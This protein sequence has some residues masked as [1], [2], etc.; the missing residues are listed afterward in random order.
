MPPTL[1]LGP[2]SPQGVDNPDPAATDGYFVGVDIGQLGLLDVLRVGTPGGTP[3]L[4]GNLQINVPATALPLNP[5]V[6]GSS[7]PLDAADDRL[8]SASIVAGNLYT[9]QNIGV[10][11]S[12][13]ASRS[14]TRDAVR[15]YELSNLTST[16]R[17]S[18]SGAIY[19]SR[20]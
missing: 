11:S 6:A 3:T 7:N 14:P 19:D 15:W 17:L 4:S 16:P 13:V 18:R 2:Y 10:D 5:T 1:D 8:G 9:A 12:G 20:R